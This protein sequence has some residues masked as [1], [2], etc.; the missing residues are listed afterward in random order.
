MIEL[1]I[2][3]QSIQI[4]LIQLGLAL[5]FALIAIFQIILWKRKKR[6]LTLPVLWTIPILIVTAIFLSVGYVKTTIDTKNIYN[7]YIEC[8]VCT[9]FGYIESMNI[10]RGVLIFRIENGPSIEAR[11]FNDELFLS[12]MF[13]N[14]DFQSQTMFKLVL[15][16]DSYVIYL[17]NTIE[18]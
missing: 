10:Q 11:F 7:Q 4:I 8:P 18:E 5:F 6:F 15:S 9:H 3:D 17:G 2:K 12:Q 1:T 13:S 16:P 14:F